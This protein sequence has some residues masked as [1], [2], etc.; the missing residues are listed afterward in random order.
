MQPES[1]SP[2][3]V[4]RHPLS[5]VV[6]I[7]TA[8]S[9]TPSFS[10]LA[11]WPAFGHWTGDGYFHSDNEV[12]LVE[13]EDAVTPVENVRVPST[14]RVSLFRQD[15]RRCSRDIVSRSTGYDKIMLHLAVIYSA[16][17][18][19]GHDTGNSNRTAW[20]RSISTGRHSLRPSRLA[21]RTARQGCG[22]RA[23]A[24]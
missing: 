2:G 9:R 4:R 14:F 1:A 7:W 16:L 13:S 21:A 10:A 6:G 18:A 24:Y 15:D 17:N 12:V 8:I 20:E 5:H 22:E 3:S 11:L 23:K 19:A